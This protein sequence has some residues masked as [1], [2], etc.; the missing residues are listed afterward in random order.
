[1]RNHVYTA[2]SFIQTTY[3]KV[4]VLLQ[5]NSPESP[6]SLD[7]M[8]RYTACLKLHFNYGHKHKKSRRSPLDSAFCRVRYAVLWWRVSSS[9]EIC[10]D[11][12]HVS[13][14]KHVLAFTLISCRMIREDYQLVELHTKNPQTVRRL[15]GIFTRSRVW[16]ALHEVMVKLKLDSV[17]LHFISHTLAVIESFHICFG[18]RNLHFPPW[19]D[20]GQQLLSRIFPCRGLE[21]D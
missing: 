11:G 15:C 4:T 9:S 14:T 13:M 5:Q 2:K 17:K 7:V 3:C 8:L 1:M 12:L 6:F 19:S 21:D 18:L 20:S 10:T 16:K